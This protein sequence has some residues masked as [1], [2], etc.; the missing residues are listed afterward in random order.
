MRYAIIENGKVANIA[1]S[2]RP[3]ADN[4]VED[5]GSAAINGGYE[6]GVFLP[7][8]EVWP[9]V[10]EYENA[11]AAHLD[12]VAQQHG[13]DNII[14]ACSYAGAVNPF[15]LESMDFIE[16]R[17]AVWQSCASI[18]NDV[19]NNIVSQPTIDEV[20]ASLPVFGE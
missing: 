13:Y 7:A 14:S 16:W 18:L 3:L 10:K 15:Q 8:P 17:G 9:S 11:V 12:A 4:W 2:D 5:D 1:V 6:N 20:I 19:Q